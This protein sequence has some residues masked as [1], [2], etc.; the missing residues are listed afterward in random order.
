MWVCAVGVRWWQADRASGDAMRLRRGA[1]QG[2]SGHAERRASVAEPETG[3]KK[4]TISVAPDVYSEL[5]RLADEMG[6]ITITELIKRAVALQKFVWENR[7]VGV[8]IEEGEKVK[9]IVLT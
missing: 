7:S 9:Q 1:A 8:L 4:L 6:G 3:Y 2:E 5:Q